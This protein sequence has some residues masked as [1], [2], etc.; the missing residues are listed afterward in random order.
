MGRNVGIW[1]D[2]RKAVVVSLDDGKQRIRSIVSK[3]QRP[4]RSS[5][6]S[7]SATPYGPQDVQSEDRR[8]RKLAGYLTQYYDR[9]AAAVRGADAILLFGPGGAKREC[10]ERLEHHRFGRRIAGV[11]PADKMTLPQIAAKVR[12][13][14]LR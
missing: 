1:I 2:H 12:R 3:L 8:Q 6:G 4:M 5:R 7:R 10:R 13:H 11:K 14:F 9:I